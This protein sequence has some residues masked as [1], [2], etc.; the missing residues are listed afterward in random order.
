MKKYL[1]S[2]ITIAVFAIGFAASASDDPEVTKKVVGKYQVT[3]SE[4]TTWYFNLKEDHTVTAKTEGMSDDDMYYGDWSEGI[5]G[6][7][8]IISFMS[9]HAGNP[10]MEFPKERI[11]SKGEYMEVGKDGWLYKGHENLEAKNPNERLKMNKQ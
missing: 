8:C 4:G 2:F 3:D 10:P 11:W 7:L 5:G 9:F 6:C 1:Y